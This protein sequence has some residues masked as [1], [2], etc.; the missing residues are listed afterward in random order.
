MSGALQPASVVNQTGRLRKIVSWTASA[1]TDIQRSRDDWRWMVDEFAGP[2]LVNLDAYTDAGM[3]IARFSSWLVRQDQG[4]DSGLSIFRPAIG[5]SDERPLLWC[6]WPL[7]RDRY[8]RGEHP[9]GYPTVVTID[10]R[11]ALRL[12]PTPDAVYTLRGEYRKAPQTLAAN[13]DVP[14]AP[15]QHHELI[16]WRALSRYLA[17]D[18]ESVVQEPR[19]TAL[20]DS[21]LFDLVRRQ[22]PH[23]TFA[24][25]LA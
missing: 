21:M 13:T 15:A 17:A 16:V 10:P 25:P 6:D 11:D 23:L 20:A 3:S 12:H 14:E 22:T 5:R 18:D 1:W 4:S 9:A 7:F 24:E 2:T 8:L 19:W